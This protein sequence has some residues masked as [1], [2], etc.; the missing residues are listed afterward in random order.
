MR[1]SVINLSHL[2]NHFCHNPKCRP[3]R[4]LLST[5]SN[6]GNNADI[7]DVIVVGGGHAGTEAAC[8]SARLGATTLL[9]THKFETVGRFD[10]FSIQLLLD[11]VLKPLQHRYSLHAW[12][13]H[14]IKW[15]CK[16]VAL[17]YISWHPITFIRDILNQIIYGIFLLLLDMVKCLCKVHFPI[18]TKKC[19]ELG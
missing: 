5:V 16:F 6:H 7:Y 18:Q 3:R 15:K 11:A 1:R 9:V 14:P 13:V 10:W 17:K 2:R 19:I 4:R 8:A 12:K